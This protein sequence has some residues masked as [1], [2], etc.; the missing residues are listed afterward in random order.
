M[1][2]DTVS[3]RTSECNSINVNRAWDLVIA[4]LPELAHFQKQ[5]FLDW[6]FFFCS[7]TL[8]SLLVSSWTLKATI[9]VEPPVGR[10]E[11]DNSSYP[12]LA[13]FSHFSWKIGIQAGLLFLHEAP[14]VSPSSSLQIITLVIN[15]K[16][17]SPNLSYFFIQILS[18]F[19]VRVVGS[20]SFFFFFEV[21]I[22][23]HF[24][25]TQVRF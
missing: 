1:R 10:H 19:S 21:T 16:T 8:Q 24:Q 9:L 4:L 20:L 15:N 22:S 23:L 18:E 11:G 6:S 7:L 25:E 13:L 2:V 5:L 3:F 14:I 12:D 17:D